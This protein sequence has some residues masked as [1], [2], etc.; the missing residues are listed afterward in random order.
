MSDPVIARIV[1]PS[2]LL[3]HDT[4]DAYRHCALLRK[5]A[6][7]ASEYEANR[8]LRLAGHV[9]DDV[10]NGIPLLHDINHRLRP[11]FSRAHFHPATS[12]LVCG[13]PALSTLPT[14][15]P[16]WPS[17]PLRWRTPF[18]RPSTRWCAARTSASPA[19]A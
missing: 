12:A 3:R 18:S 9:S 8:H 16:P 14:V 10:T 19:V 5:G 1:P 11:F 6:R 17:S 2:F 4:P 7:I 13:C 15:Q